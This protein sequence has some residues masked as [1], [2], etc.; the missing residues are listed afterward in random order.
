MC[1][2]A[3]LF[4]AQ[5]SSSAIYQSVKKMCDQMRH[6]G[7]DDEG[8]YLHEQ[9]HFAFG[10]RRLAIIDLS[11]N[12]HQP[13]ADS[14]QQAWITF[15][16][17]I[18][19]YPEL[20]CLLL[21]E[22]CVFRT[23]SDTEVILQAYLHWGIASFDKLRG[24]FAF[25]LY[26]IK[27]NCT[28]LV[29][30]RS[31]IK[32]LFYHQTGKDLRFASE[33]KA[34]QTA[35]PAIANDPGWQIRLLAFGHIPEPYTTLKDVWSLTKGHY[36]K[37]NHQDARAEIK[38]YVQNTPFASIRNPA[39]ACD[40]IRSYLTA[41]VKRQLLADAPIGVFLSGGIDSSLITLLAASEKGAQLNTL[42][43]YFTEAAFNEKKYQQA[44]A[45]LITGN[46]YH[47]LIQRADFEQAFPQIL[48]AM[49][50]PTNDGINT[51][52]ISQAAREN[53]L[54]SV[55]SGLG[56]DELFGGYPSFRRM[57]Y[58]QKLRRLPQWVKAFTEF[59]PVDRFKRMSFLQHEDLVAEYLFLR[60][61][62][63]P[64]AIAKILGA[65]RKEV[66][67]LLFDHPF[68]PKSLDMEGP[69]RASWFEQNLYMQNQL[70]PDT[71]FMSMSHGLEVRVPFL[72]EDFMQVVAAI[73]PAIRFADQPAKKLLVDSFR[74]LIPELVWN[75]P[76]MGFTFPLQDW[77]RKN[78]EITDEQ[79]YHGKFSR[80]II[81]RF[82]QDQLHWSKAF[83]LYQIQRHE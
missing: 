54:K 42:S 35:E 27:Q 74:H 61:L 7:P 18:Y 55:L 43:I 8:I 33:V 73:D 44:V 52:F 9:Q 75:R 32:P 23:A 12:G 31:G 62:F 24:M 20:R 1:R 51:W 77:M 50:Q 72:D 15:N 30:D 16:G 41:A 59:I 19:N 67:Q 58:L 28:Y 82:K 6:G 46:K 60:G 76:K 25:A 63:S 39:E 47:K 22:G 71:D 56:G 21:K 45:K 34:F 37:W 38:S 3:G 14:Q 65:D 48:K 79:A 17:E 5:M 29:R 64:L 66:N 78:A 36:L 53:G 11:E 49:D 80:D 2:I 68:L 70:L 10:H 69:E 81:R 40:K 57:N 13:M 26:D 4:A 83:A